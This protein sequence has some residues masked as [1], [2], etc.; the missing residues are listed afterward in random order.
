MK[1]GRILWKALRFSVRAC[2]LFLKGA[3]I[4][5]YEFLEEE[6]PYPP[7][8][9]IRSTIT[10]SGAA[11]DSLKFQ[12]VFE[13]RGAETVQENGLAID[14]LSGVLGSHSLSERVAI[15]VQADKIVDL[16]I[17]AGFSRVETEIPAM[18]ATPTINDTPGADNTPMVGGGDDSSNCLDRGV[19]AEQVHDW[20]T[21]DIQVYGGV[22]TDIQVHTDGIL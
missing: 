20:V 7:V 2:Y 11:R 4:A 14:D 1:N 17:S 16:A 10:E 15:P 12:D 6:Q 13:K 3:A 8:N 22:T 21:T 19:T 5:L 9:T 18:S